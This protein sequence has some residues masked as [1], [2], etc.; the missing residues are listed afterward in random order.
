MT[1]NHGDTFVLKIDNRWLTIGD[2]WDKQVL[3][4]ANNGA[5]TLVF[6]DKSREIA[7]NLEEGQCI[8]VI[9]VPKIGFF[10]KGND[11]YLNALSRDYSTAERLTLQ[12][13]AE[14]DLIPAQGD[15]QVKIYSEE[16]PIIFDSNNNRLKI[17][18]RDQDA[19]IFEV[20]QEKSGTCQAFNSSDADN[21]SS[22]NSFETTVESN[23][24]EK[25]G[26]KSRNVEKVDVESKEAIEDTVISPR[27]SKVSQKSVAIQM[28]TNESFQFQND[29]LIK[30]EHINDVLKSQ[31]QIHEDYQRQVLDLAEESET[32]AN[33]LDKL[34]IDVPR[35]LKMENQRE[36]YAAQLKAF[37]ANIPQDITELLNTEKTVSSLL[38][39]LL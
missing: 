12:F 2:N 21:F 15:C 20:V 32:L 5:A 28:T 25:T 30:L 18:E 39:D 34:K 17:G 13:I 26:R 16:A 3:I 37:E 9:F 38:Q 27:S 11:N 8:G 19:T 36:D 22:D 4:S 14:C 1:L 24:K 10:K 7:K 23:S 35:L 31:V 33:R 6:H 29:A